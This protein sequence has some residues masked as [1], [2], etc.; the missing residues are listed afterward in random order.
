MLKANLADM[1]LESHDPQEAASRFI[2]EMESGLAEA[3]DAVA[4]AMVE[5]RKTEKQLQET[6]ALCDEWDAKTDEA[7]RAGDE[8]EAR[9]ALGRKA[10]LQKQ[11]QA[12]E[13]DL[14]RQ[15]Q[16]VAKMKADLSALQTKIQDIKRQV[17]HKR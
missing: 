8:S 7:L 15:T 17:K 4:S 2:A 13:Q 6:K 5:E 1:L 11:A 3:K 12:L 14:D 16:A 9:R 10:S